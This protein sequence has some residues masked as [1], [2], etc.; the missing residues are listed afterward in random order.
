MRR[1]S[2][3]LCCVNF[4]PE[5]SLCPGNIFCN[6]TEKTI[7]GHYAPG[8]KKERDENGVLVF[9]DDNENKIWVPERKVKELVTPGYSQ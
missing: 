2:V 1:K 4:T 3:F 5:R 9:S 6:R 8:I 7:P